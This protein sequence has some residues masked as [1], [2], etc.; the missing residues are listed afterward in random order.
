MVPRPQWIEFHLNTEG[1]W[2]R[3]TAAVTPPGVVAVVRVSFDLAVEKRAATES[4]T[5]YLDKLLALHPFGAASVRRWA[6]H[7]DDAVVM[8]VLARNRFEAAQ[9]AAAQGFAA[10]ALK[11]VAEEEMDAAAW[12]ALLR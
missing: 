10:A 6:V 9:Q 5:R 4:G 8:L 2:L 1:E 3:A 12:Q 11:V 7:H